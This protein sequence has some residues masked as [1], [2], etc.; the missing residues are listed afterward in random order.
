MKGRISQAVDNKREA[1]E[2]RVIRTPKRYLPITSFYTTSAAGKS[3]AAKKRIGAR[4]LNKPRLP[5]TGEEGQASASCCDEFMADANHGE[6]RKPVVRRTRPN[7]ALRKWVELMLVKNHDDSQKLVG[8]RCRIFW[9][10]DSVWYSAY[11]KEYNMDT[12]CHHVVYD[13][14]DEENMLLR[15]QKI[16]F[17]L[18]MG[19]IK[20][21]CL[22]QYR[23][24][25]SDD[26]SEIMARADDNFDEIAP[27][28]VTW[29][30]LSGHAA[31]PALVLDEELVAGCKGLKG[32]VGQ[33]SYPVQFFGSHD[34][35]RVK[36]TDA[37]P[38]I[39]GL[40]STLQIKCKRVA[41]VRGL[42]EAE[43]YVYNKKKLPEGMLLMQKDTTEDEVSEGTSD[44]DNDE[45]EDENKDKDEEEEEEEQE[46]DDDDE[47]EQ[48]GDNEEEQEGDEEEKEEQEGDD[49]MEQEGDEEEK[50]E[51]E[52]DDE[53]EQE[54]DEEEKEEQE[55]DDEMEQEG[56]EEE[57][58]EQE[59]DDEE[60]QE[61]DEEE[62]EEQ[63][64]DDEE[65]QEEG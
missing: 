57:K 61:G 17:L 32:K 3:V 63:E 2:K 54:G 65:E 33:K 44:D 10:L 56:D 11:L 23:T 6:A 29:A 15:R 46:G 27:G 47:E 55:G 50:E 7:L 31:W 20:K 59:G 8:L 52:G 22:S 43:M 19:E 58:E 35:A 64:G 41:F 48:E 24:L 9:P 1:R 30:K 18:S 40:L 14:G 34:L 51:Q 38:F 62:K 53:M 25:S 37:T 45:D 42:Q 49:E 16:Q 21:L 39:P 12:C 60:E 4:Q 5:Q 26:L 13:D 28:D 36:N